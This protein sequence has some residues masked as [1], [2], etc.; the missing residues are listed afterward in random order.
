MDT[1]FPSQAKQSE[2]RVADR[3]AMLTRIS[4]TADGHQWHE[5]DSQDISRSGMLLGTQRHLAPQ[6]LLRLQFRLP[7]GKKSQALIIADARVAR[8]V[9]RHN[10]QVAAGLEFTTL[11]SPDIKVV[12]EFVCRIMGLHM[13]ESHFYT[14]AKED[15]GLSSFSMEKLL[16]EAEKE[17]S[18]RA[19]HRLAWET[20]RSR[21]EKRKLWLNRGI[22]IILFALLVFLASKVYQ[23]IQGLLGRITPG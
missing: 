2:K 18:N 22:R 20:A 3:A 11:R 23:F 8:L 14:L 19:E 5:D 7:G 13:D 21:Q 16:D 4:W 17:R 15:G 10:R 12:H 1:D 9:H 6:T